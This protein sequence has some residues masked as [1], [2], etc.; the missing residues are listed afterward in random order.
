MSSVSSKDVATLRQKT[1]LGM[2]DCKRAL[3]EAGGDFDKAIEYLR[4]SGIAKGQSRSGRA[5]G[6]GLVESYIHPGNRLGVLIEVAC[7]TDFVARSDEFRNLVH[8]LAMQV[9][10]S[11]PLVV[12][13]EDVPPQM[14]E[15]ELEIYRAQIKE[16]KKPAEVIDRITKGKLEKFFQQSCLLEQP[17]IKEPKMRVK[18]IVLEKAGKLKEN[19]E[20]KRFARFSLGD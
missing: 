8:E 3:Q 2:M 19:I 17:Y 20:V 15:K 10:A 9:A 5:T 13:R 18:E 1:G 4:K 11:M 16:Q 6:E 12:D 7:E 14:I